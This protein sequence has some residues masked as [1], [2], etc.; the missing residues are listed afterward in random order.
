MSTLNLRRFATPSALKQITPHH[1][2]S[3]F[4][5]Y[6]EF[7]RTRG[8]RWP[9]VDVQ[10]L[11]YESLV[12]IIMSPD[13]DTP[14]ELANGLFFIHEMATD[15]G[16]DSL[17]EEARYS[18]L[19]IEGDGD[20]TP[21]DVAVQVWLSDPEMLERT[22]AEQFL[23]RPRSFE[24]YQANTSRLPD[25]TNPSDE[26]IRRLERS[27]DEWF[28]EKKRG[29]GARVFVYPKD[30]GVWF[31]VRHGDP[32]KREG[33]LENGESSSVF[34]RPEKFDVLVY[35]PD[36]GELRMNA[37][38]KGE[39]GLYRTKFGLHLFG[40]EDF[41][42]ASQKYTLE[43]LRTHGAEALVCTDVEGLDSVTLKSIQFY[44][45]G[46]HNEIEERKADDIFAALADRGRGLPDRVPIIKASFQVKFSDAKTPRT[47]T[48]R[49]PCAAQFKRDS[50]SAVLEDWLTKRGFVVGREQEDHATAEAVLASH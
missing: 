2:V 34:Y 9:P 30:D 17:L 40:R 46:A 43:P 37:R 22:H 44:W 26:V 5:P 42:P 47:L 33:S 14:A 24:Y 48:I 38:S 8:L 10:R 39:K 36:T 35:R 45:G 28:D 16:M 15:S 21:A 13:T 32:F 3:F 7:L 4:N 12:G 1:L 6:A 25:F 20:M 23:V 49:V 31:L 41:F 11:D 18:G 29:R 27:L 50:D 19:G